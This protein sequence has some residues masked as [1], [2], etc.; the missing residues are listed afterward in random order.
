[1]SL[2]CLIIARNEEKKLE[3]CLA[4]LI[5]SDEIVVVLDRSIDNSKEISTKFTHSVFKGHW[6]FEGD[7]RN[8]GISKCS[9]KWIL[10]VD[11]DL[12]GSQALHGRYLILKRGKKLFHL[13]KLPRS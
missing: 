4:N 10:E 8:F 7:R 2:S 13:A 1:M 9:M 6:E 12:T 3:K 11:A 5:F